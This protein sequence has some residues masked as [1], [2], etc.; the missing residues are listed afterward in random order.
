MIGVLS[1]E[2]SYPAEEDSTPELI[3]SVW[4]NGTWG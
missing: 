1:V 2:R 3:Y 4:A